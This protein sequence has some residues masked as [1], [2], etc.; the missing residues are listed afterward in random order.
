MTN[1]QTQV[2]KDG[3]KL[4]VTV[5]LTQDH[6][7]SKSGKT[8]TT[9]ST[10]GNKEVQGADGIYLGVNCYRYATPKS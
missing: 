8:L 3:K 7:L 10:R 9:A 2:S 4:T 1:V 5:D 6:G